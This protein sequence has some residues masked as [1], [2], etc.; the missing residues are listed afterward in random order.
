MS[1]FGF[2]IE[3][4]KDATFLDQAGEVINGVSVR[5][6]LT[7]YDEIRTITVKSDDPE[8]IRAACLDLVSKRKQIAEISG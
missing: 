8:L 6:R 2:V 4:V 7:D 1:E 3:S 5:V